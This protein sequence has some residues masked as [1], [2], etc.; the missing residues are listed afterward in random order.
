MEDIII[1]RV[2]A[3]DFVIV[4]AI[5]KNKNKLISNLYFAQPFYSKRRSAVVMPS[6]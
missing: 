3:I 4:A 1:I 2:L 6:K 5:Y